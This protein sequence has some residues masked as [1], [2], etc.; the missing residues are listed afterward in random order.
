MGGVE[1][2]GCFRQ[3]FRASG[4]E[5]LGGEDSWVVEG[6]SIWRFR[7]DEFRMLGGI[8]TL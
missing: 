3:G 1:A 7:L 6:R 5:G 8:S 4:D 2:A